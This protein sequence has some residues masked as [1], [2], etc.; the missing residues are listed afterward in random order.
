MKI[1][2][3]DF[4]KNLLFTNNKPKNMKFKKEN[5]KKYQTKECPATTYDNGIKIIFKDK[6]KIKILY[7]L[8]TFL[9]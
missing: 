9:K 4:L 6:V 5:G 7:F 2:K 3:K 8:S 1:L